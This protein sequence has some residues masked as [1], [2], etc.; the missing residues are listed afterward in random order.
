MRILLRQPCSQE[1]TVNLLRRVLGAGL[2]VK[3]IVVCGH[4]D[5]GA[6]KALL[7]PESTA[8]MPTVSSWL[9]NGKA[10][11]MV[12]DALRQA[13][14]PSS[15]TLRRVTEQNVLMQL[16]HLKTHPSVAGAMAQGKVSTSGWIYDIATGDVSILEEEPT[17][18][19]TVDR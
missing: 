6:M 9:T 18:L 2:G 5:C 12:S 8:K 11:L 16:A 7:H 1:E 4:S 17:T 14:E 19:Q 3:H 10:A 15:E 13:D